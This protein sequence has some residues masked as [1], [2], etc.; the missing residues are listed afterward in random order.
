MA[1]KDFEKKKFVRIGTDG[2]SGGKE[3]LVSGNG[4][5]WVV[6]HTGTLSEVRTLIK[7]FIGIGYVRKNNRK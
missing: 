3:V 1:K 4:W 7:A 6:V 2:F 5:Q